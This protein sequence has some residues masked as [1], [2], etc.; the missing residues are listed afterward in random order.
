VST[1][2]RSQR[3]VLPLALFAVLLLLVPAAF[4]AKG[5]GGG[6]KPG[7]GGSG[8]SG[9]ISLAPLVSD[10][11][12]N[13]LPNWGDIVAF[14]I[15][16]TATS[17][18]YVDLYCYQNGVFVVGGS[19]GYFDGSLDTRNFGLPS[20]ASG[21]AS[22]TAYLDMSTSQGMQHLGSTSFTVS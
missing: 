3:L 21:P 2:S 13:G 15:S 7:G 10:V 12:G 20:W 16:T 9:T 19:R 8:G 22:C 18:P 11:N 14:N 6:H 1:I 4:A 17:Q 5:G